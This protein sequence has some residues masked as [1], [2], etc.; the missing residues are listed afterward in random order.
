METKWGKLPQLSGWAIIVEDYAPLRVLLGETLAEIGLQSLHFETADAALIF[1]LQTQGGCLL[2]IVDQG[3]PGRLQ[4]AAF[5]DM[6]K[7]NWPATS[8]ILISGIELEPATV[9]SSTIYLQKP[10]SIDA[11]VHAVESCLQPDYS[12]GKI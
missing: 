5:I 3:L 11:F 1:L 4:G 7:A 12:A 8:A 10:W 2:V 9:P 6:V